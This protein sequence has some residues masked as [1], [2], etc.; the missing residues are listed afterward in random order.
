[1][2]L[3]VTT[4]VEALSLDLVLNEE[5]RTDR[6]SIARSLKR[7]GLHL[8]TDQV[9]GRVEQWSWSNSPDRMGS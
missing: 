7:C 8:I 6:D 4:A 1:M 3:V 5:G 2:S 9:Y